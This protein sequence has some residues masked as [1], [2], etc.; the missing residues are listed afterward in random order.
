[1]LMMI[2]DMKAIHDSLIV[3]FH[4]E[5]CFCSSFIFSNPLCDLVHV[6][7]SLWAAVSSLANGGK[8]YFTDLYKH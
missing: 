5:L 8:I 4:V 1:M 2:D 3:Y 7:F 6:T